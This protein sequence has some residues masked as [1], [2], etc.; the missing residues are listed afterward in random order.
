MDGPESLCCGNSV[1][2]AIKWKQ[3]S[4]TWNDNLLPVC[5]EYYQEC[6]FFLL[7]H[8]NPTLRCF[9]K[10]N[11]QTR[12]E[13]RILLLVQFILLYKVNSVLSENE[14][15]NMIPSIKHGFQLRTT[16]QEFILDNCVYCHL[17]LL[18]IKLNICSLSYTN[19]LQPVGRFGFE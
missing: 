6:D 8:L 13:C 19:T 18:S 5:A 3:K 17:Q 4:L 10:Y 16:V 11:C 1:I 15:M 14:I 7:P 12:R 9:A 2:P